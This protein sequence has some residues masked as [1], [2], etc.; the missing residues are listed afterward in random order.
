MCRTA[1]F[2]RISFDRKCHR[3][4]FLAR[5]VEWCKVFERKTYWTELANSFLDRNL[6]QEEVGNVAEKILLNLYG[7]DEGTLNTQDF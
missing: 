1:G 7:G 4:L 3:G 6:N 5:Q 2:T